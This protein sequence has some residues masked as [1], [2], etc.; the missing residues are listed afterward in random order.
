MN[1]TLGIPRL[2]EILMAAARIIET[3]IMTLPLFNSSRENAESIAKIL[4]PVH[5]IGTK[6]FPAKIDR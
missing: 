6:K 3:P 1:V 2:R 4:N 5:F